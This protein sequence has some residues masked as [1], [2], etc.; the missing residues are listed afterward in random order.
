MKPSSGRFPDL[1]WVT[2]VELGEG[3]LGRYG[4]VPLDRLDALSGGNS[5]DSALFTDVRLS[6]SPRLIGEGLTVTL[7]VNNAFD[8]E[9]PICFPCGVIGMS[10]VVHDLPGRV[11]Y[12][13]MRFQR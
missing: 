9:P 13:R 10:Q 8:E 3:P 7:G 2:T 6:Y 1:R 12:L 11:G 5:V 4:G